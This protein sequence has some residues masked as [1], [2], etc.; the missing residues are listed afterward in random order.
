MSTMNPLITFS[1]ISKNSGILTKR[2]K[3]INGN[4]EKDASECKMGSGTAETVSILPKD[5][6]PFLRTLQPR[7]AITHGTTQF[8]KVQITT[9]AKQE[10]AIPHGLPVV[11]RTRDHFSYS[12]GPGLLL[13]DNDS[14]RSNAVALGD[15]ALQPFCPNELINAIAGFFPAIASAASVSSCST[16]SCIHDAVSGEELRGPGAGFHLYL[17]PENA[18]DAPRFLKVLGQRLMLGEYGRVEFSRSGAVLIRS[19]VD[20]LVAS[21]E[22]LDFVAGAVCDNGLEQRLPDPVYHPGG[23]LDTEALHDLTPEEDKAYQEIIQQLKEKGAPDQER[24]KAAYLDQEAE[25]LSSGS[26]GKISIKKARAAVEARQNHILA[27]DDLLFFQNH[28]EPVTVAEVL[29]DGELYNGESLADPLEPDYSGSSKTTAKFYWNNGEPRINSYAH[30]TTVYK[31]ASITYPGGSTGIDPASAFGDVPTCEPVTSR[32]IS[33]GVMGDPG[34]ETWDREELVYQVIDDVSLINWL[35]DHPST[36]LTRKERG[37]FRD[38]ILSNTE[39]DPASR[40][41]VAESLKANFGMSKPVTNSQYKHLK[42]ARL[43]QGNAQYSWTHIQVSDDFTTRHSCVG[44]EGQMWGY[45]E[46]SGIYEPTQLEKFQNAIAREYSTVNNRKSTDNAAIAHTI[47]N[48]SVQPNFFKDAVV[49]V[50]CKSAFY[51]VEGEEITAQPYTKKLRQRFKLT[52]DPTPGELPKKSLWSRY[53]NATFKHSDPAHTAEQIELLSMIC[54]GMLMGVFAQIQIAVLLLGGG[55]NG[56]S[57]LIELLQSFFPEDARAAV[58]LH[59]FNDEYSRALLAGTRIN[60]VGEIDKNRQLSADFKDIVGAETMVTARHPY[61]KGFTFI[62][63]CAHLTAG[64]AYPSTNDHSEGFY[65]RWRVLQFLNRVKGTKIPHLG[66][67]IATDEAGIFLQWSMQGGKKLIAARYMLPETIAHTEAMD[68]WKS[69][70]DSVKSFFNDT[71]VI[72]KKADS[73]SFI[74]TSDLY[75]TYAAWCRTTG[76]GALKRSKFIPVIRD[77]YGINKKDGYNVLRNF[78]LQ[79]QAFPLA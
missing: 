18:G 7:Q 66:R 22:R 23:L 63:T 59:R 61:G 78:K 29:E 10:Q 57:V 27:D 12:N 15:R 25:K 13:L 34:D 32:F 21:P 14:P 73:S 48:D 45:N 62:P 54:G 56:K 51:Q 64:N 70:Q 6:G 38:D 72:K 50:P 4:V 76:T 11:A 65:R 33:E 47:Y 44:A 41:E 20:L 49:G 68:D 28:A 30:G 71:E 1:K 74:K 39:L 26:D 69:E 58:Q 24:V 19:P 17:F 31:F 36:E 5:F 43:K 3:L 9:A 52:A 42:E 77:R 67:R 46:V 79:D 75:Q 2:M 40:E 35:F 60:I 8:P 55:S 16:S 53:L 37:C